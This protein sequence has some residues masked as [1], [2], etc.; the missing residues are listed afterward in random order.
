MTPGKEDII[1]IEALDLHNEEVDKFE[2][3]GDDAKD[4]TLD[5]VTHML[6]FTPE[7]PN[8][9]QRERY[10]VSINIVNDEGKVIDT[11]K[12]TINNAPEKEKVDRNHHFCFFIC[13]NFFNF[14]L[15]KQNFANYYTSSG[16]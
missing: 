15:R 1:K 2:L 5:P 7:D 4:F 10:D 3:A 14:S 6:K 16:K 11:K 13:I 8:A 12:V 9:E